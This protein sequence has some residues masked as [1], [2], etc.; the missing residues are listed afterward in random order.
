M[1]P[2]DDAS[3]NGHGPTG[4]LDRRGPWRQVDSRWVWV[5]PNSPGATGGIALVLVLWVIALLTVM[6]LGLTATQRTETALSRNQVDAAR[7]RALAEAAVDYAVYRLLTDE[8][9]EPASMPD[10]EDVGGV[11]AWVPDGQPHLWTFGGETLEIRI[12]NE[13]SRFDLNVVERDQLEALFLALAVDPDEAGALADR[14]LDWRD[15]DDLP[16]LLGAEDDDYMAA[17]YPYGAKDE[18]FA[19]AEE[20]QQVLGMTPALYRA[21]APGLTVDGDGGDVDETFASPLVLAALRGR[22]V[23]D[24][25]DE[26]QDRAAMRAAGDEPPTRVDRGGPLYR[27]RVT[28]VVGGRQTRTLQTL[29]NLSPR[30]PSLYGVRWRRIGRGT[31]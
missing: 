10:G 22:L 18:P 27:I 6:A 16:R 31:E 13:A 15:E 14:I 20:L 2:V 1:A 17:G 30:G 8:P 28:W 23:E 21:V 25:I 5:R 4:S 19:S 12:E 3:D 11:S 9:T 7:F 29:I 26:Q 24:I